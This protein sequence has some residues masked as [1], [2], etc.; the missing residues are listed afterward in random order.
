MPDKALEADLGAAGHAVQPYTGSMKDLRQDYLST[1]LAHL[2]DPAS[3]YQGQFGTCAATMAQVTM[4]SNEPA[5]YPG[6]FT[7]GMIDRL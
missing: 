3:V 5:A 6:L 2:A 1:L 4:V 7:V